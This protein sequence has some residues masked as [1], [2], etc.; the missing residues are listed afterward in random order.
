MDQNCSSRNKIE[1]SGRNQTA[2]HGKYVNNIAIFSSRYSVCLLYDDLDETPLFTIVEMQISYCRAQTRPST[3]S[4]ISIYS[5]PYWISS[6]QKTQNT[7]TC[8]VIQD[9]QFQRLFKYKIKNLKM[10]LMRSKRCQKPYWP[11]SCCPSLLKMQLELMTWSSAI[12]RKRFRSRS[13]ETKMSV[14]GPKN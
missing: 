2:G 9:R 12:S 8:T 5:T 6:W 3:V 13:D 4:I 7:I 1:K 11:N 14:P 10:L